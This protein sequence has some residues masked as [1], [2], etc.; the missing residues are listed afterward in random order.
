MKD[1]ARVENAEGAETRPLRWDGVGGLNR[2]TEQ[3]IASAI[4]VHRHLGPG[5]LESA[6]EDLVVD[7]LVIVEIKAV[8]KFL[9]VHPA[10]LLTY[11][12][13][14]NKRLG[15]LINFQV[16][17]LKNGIKRIANHYTDSPGRPSTS[18]P[19]APTPEEQTEPRLLNNPPR[20]SPRLCVSAGETRP[21]PNEGRPH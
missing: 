13:A 6:Y 2:L 14:T 19:S 5:L 16:P 21:H 7:D 8:E 12:K 17:V 9:P 18:A 15:L 11:L 1:K 3:I 10:Q 20:I 4:E